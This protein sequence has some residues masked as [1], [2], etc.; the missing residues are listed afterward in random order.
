MFNS[1]FQ[2][3][4]N[5]VETFTIVYFIMTYLVVNEKYKRS[6]FLLTW[7]TILAEVSFFN[8]Q[9]VPYL[10]ETGTQILTLFLA[11]N[12]ISDESYIIKAFISI[13][14]YVILYLC[15]VFTLFAFSLIMELEVAQLP[16]QEYFNIIIVISKIL[17]FCVCYIIVR[18]HKRKVI[19]SLNNRWIILI[20]L[21][22][23]LFIL[24]MNFLELILRGVINYS[25]LY[26]SIVLLI[27]S[28]I[29]LYFLLIFLERESDKRTHE[30]LV[31]QQLKYQKENIDDIREMNEEIRKIRHD[32]KHK[33][34][35]IVEGLKDNKVKEMLIFLES[36]YDEIDKTN[37]IAFSD[38]E[39]LNYIL[40]SKNKLAYQNNAKLKCEI[41]Y[42]HIDGIKDEDLII[43]L[44]NLLDNA[45]EHTSGE[46]H[47]SLKIASIKGLLHL[48]VSNSISNTNINTM[49]TRKKDIENHGFG[50]KSIRNIV[51]QYNGNMIE[52]IRDEK[53][54]IDI[55]LNPQ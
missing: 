19:I 15:N 54:I 37:V 9:E 44:G 40:Q 25:L 10:I 20:P 28:C 22:F 35:F 36:S 16:Q 33:L 29:L 3:I 11:V 21:L 18:F 27:V 51:T 14:S 38:N 48:Q 30:M 32:M 23:M 46:K 50:M 45:I 13:F 2:L 24:A 4:I 52:S 42:E 7:I 43:L 47:I 41:S 1:I 12:F 17:Y 8:Y 34:E 53:F 39:T 26:L 55:I 31:I 6:I 5:I 49:T